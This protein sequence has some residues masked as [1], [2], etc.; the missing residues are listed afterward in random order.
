MPIKVYDHGSYDLHKKAELDFEHQLAILTNSA[1][2]DKLPILGPYAIGFETIK[3]NDD[4]TEGIGL[5]IYM[6]GKQVIY[7]PS[8][9]RK[10]TLKTGLF[11]ILADSQAF[12]PATEEWVSIIR[13]QNER[14]VGS[15]IPKGDVPEVRRGAPSAIRSR[16]FLDPISKTA[17]EAPSCQA[18]WDKWTKLAEKSAKSSSMDVFDVALEMGKSASKMLIDSM[19]SDTRFLNDMLTGYTPER[20]DMFKT[21]ALSL[22]PDMYTPK[23]KPAKE[24]FGTLVQ[25]F[26]KSAKALTAEEQKQLQQDGFFIKTASESIFAEVL[27]SAA[28]NLE[29]ST[30]ADPAIYKLL[31]VGSKEFE[32]ALVLQPFEYDWYGTELPCSYD[33]KRLYDTR[34]KYTNM[35]ETNYV[36]IVTNNTGTDSYMKHSKNLVGI[37][38][39]QT[40]QQFLKVLEGI[41]E[42]LS[43]M[44]HLFERDVLVTPEGQVMEVRKDMVRTKK[45]TEANVFRSTYDNCVIQES[46]GIRKIYCDCKTVLVPAGTRVLHDVKE[47]I[48]KKLNK[49]DL[50]YDEYQKRLAEELSQTGPTYSSNADLCRSTFHTLAG[51]YDRVRIKTDGRTY[52]INKDVDDK[53]SEDDFSGSTKE[54]ALHLVNKYHVS[55]SNALTML[56]KVASN[57]FGYTEHHWYIQK[58]AAQYN[59]SDV[60]GYARGS[61]PYDI[62]VEMSYTDRYEPGPQIDVISTEGRVFTAQSKDQ[63]MDMIHQAAEKGIK[64]VMD[65]SVVKMMIN[66][67]S[68]MNLVGDYMKTFL[69]AIDKIGRTM[70]LVLSHE[71]AFEA[72]Y[73]DTQLQE[74][75]ETLK[76]G[77]ESMSDTVLFLRN[78]SL[79]SVDLTAAND[80]DDEDLTTAIT[81]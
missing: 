18:L 45:N 61:S 44:D 24:D 25:P 36:A 52:A 7:I 56:R 16:E 12:R 30:V 65:A 10:N 73:G 6:I 53:G 38:A 50:E 33:N 2:M 37:K 42:P 57:G 4:N 5:G 26:D 62:P 43:D 3:K 54:A 29:L 79:L 31:P 28:E 17:A 75:I 32:P 70:F 78:K 71:D 49:Q 68:P 63:L 23:V 35:R 47:T 13:E 27:D 51:N 69:H 55:P 80:Q 77:M 72:Q 59:M 66:T 22:Y 58:Q 67:S 1:L 11:M 64:E 74:L 46:D 14:T 34:G 76:S 41:G 60:Y 19:A 81:H 48:E 8:F 9:Y 20:I 39:V 15:N 40:P 21:A